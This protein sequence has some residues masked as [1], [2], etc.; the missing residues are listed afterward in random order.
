MPEFAISPPNSLLRYDW[1]SAATHYAKHGKADADAEEGKSIRLRDRF[2]YGC[3]QK[4]VPKTPAVFKSPDDLSR[5]VDVPGN[6]GSCARHI[7]LGES[8]TCI[9]EPVNARTVVK[10]TDD[11][12]HIVDAYGNRGSCAR[13]IDLGEAT[14]GVEEA[15]G[16]LLPAVLKPPDDLP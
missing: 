10:R 9:E 12:P 4:A 15:V 8:S 16:D 7:D 6:R 2:D 11:L 13:H 14:A 1:L 3:S 5:V